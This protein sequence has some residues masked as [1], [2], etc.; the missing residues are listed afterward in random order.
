MIEQMNLNQPLF[1]FLKYFEKF[2]GLSFVNADRGVM[3]AGNPP[4]G[5]ADGHDRCG[6]RVHPDHLRLLPCTDV[7]QSQRLQIGK[8]IMY[9]YFKY[10]QK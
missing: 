9:I 3:A 5:V 1:M 8:E 6:G 2:C 7:P 4:E 10:E